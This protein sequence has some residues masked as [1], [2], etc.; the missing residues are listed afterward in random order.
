VANRSGAPPVRSFGESLSAPV[1][2]PRHLAKRLLESRAF[3]EGER[4]QVTVLFADIKGSTSLIQD[5]DPEEADQRLGP[6]LQTMIDAVH[7]YEGTVNRIEGD[8]IMALFG[9]PLAHEDSAVRAAYAALDMQNALRPALDAQPAIRVGLHAGEVVVRAIHTD[10]SVDYDAIGA[11]VHLAARME[12]MAEPG[13]IYCTSQVVRLAEG[14]IETKSLG[15]IPVK[16]FR[17]PLELFEI[18]GHTAART[19]WEVTAARGLTRFIN[20]NAESAT[21]LEAMREAASG[22]GKLI[23]VVGEPGTGKSRLVHELLNAPDASAWTVLKTASTSYTKNTPYLAF[24]NLIR[25]RR[26]G[27]F[28]RR[29][30]HSARS[31]T[32]LYRRCA[33]CSI[34]P[35]TTRSG[36]SWSL[37][38]GAS[39]SWRPPGPL[40]CAAPSGG[41]CC[42]GSRT[43]SGPMPRQGR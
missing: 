7:R 28:W 32:R 6:T 27:A 35:S 5:L 39:A 34:C 11:T 22:H 15:A 37:R 29:S 21:L 1:H 8:G 20:R 16:G 13:T 23:G 3:I 33:P 36:R 14:L 24:S 25:T 26:T 19:R 41:R 38:H 9:A 31:S 30:R 10:F 42:C 17:E 4:K 12:Q 40:S 2:L 18:V 43:C